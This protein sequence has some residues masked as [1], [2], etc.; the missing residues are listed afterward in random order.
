MRTSIVK[1]QIRDLRIGKRGVMLN[2]NIQYENKGGSNYNKV[3]EIWDNV[4]KENP[5]ELRILLLGKE[6]LLSANKSVSGKSV[7]YFCFLENED[8]DKF[9]VSISKNPNIRG[10][11]SIQGN[12]ICVDN[13]KNNFK[14][15]CPSF[16]EI[17]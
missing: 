12:E 2:N 16:V 9:N 15:I 14:Y 4:I 8:L 5:N 11:L 1:T 13:G 3:S 6:Y 17:L 7:V 10:S